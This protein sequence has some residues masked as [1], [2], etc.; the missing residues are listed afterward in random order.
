M[1]SSVAHEHRRNGTLARIELGLDHRALCAPVRVGPQIQ[2]FCLQQ[3][4]VEERIDVRPLLRRY[5]ARKDGSAEFL[6]HDAVLEK[7]LLHLHWVCARYVDLVDRND[8]R[9]AGVLGVRDGFDCL[10]HHLIVRGDDEHYD[11]RHLGTASAHRGERLVARRVEESDRLSTRKRDVVRTDVLRDP[12]RLT[13][14][15]VRFA[16]VVEQRRLSMVD[17]THDGHD[18]RARLELFRGVVG[19]RRRLQISGVFFLFHGLESELAGNQL[20]LIEV[21]P[22]VDGHH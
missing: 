1:E 6:E 17:V 8:H 14:D 4:L 21:E 10:R 12:A 19:D 9:H 11:V 13:G 22:L 3:N 2:D 18:R 5:F 16:D 7:I 15:D 20:D